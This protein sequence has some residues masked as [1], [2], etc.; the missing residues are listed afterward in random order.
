MVSSAGAPSL[1]PRLK[2]PAPRCACEPACVWH[3]LLT[4]FGVHTMKSPAAPSKPPSEFVLNQQ[5]QV[6]IPP[7]LHTAWRAPMPPSA[8]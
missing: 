8:K 3:V 4:L 6:G 1:A 5:G 7:P 2:V